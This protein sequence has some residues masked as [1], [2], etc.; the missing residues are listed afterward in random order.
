MI[1]KEIIYIGIGSNLNNPKRQ[2]LK[3]LIQLKTIP[4]SKLL[5]VV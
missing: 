1:K 2:V 5:K 4:K 3:A